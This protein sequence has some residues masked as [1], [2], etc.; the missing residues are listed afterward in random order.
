MNV[1][2]FVPRV[3]QQDCLLQ[4]GRA[5]ERQRDYLVVATPGGG[6]TKLALSFAQSLLS[7]GAITHIH[8]VT[9]STTLR[10]QWNKEA[11]LFG[12]QL[13]RR[14]NGSLRNY[15]LPIDVGG[16]AATYH[17]VASDADAHAMNIESAP[18][19]SLVIF[20]ECHHLGDLLA[21]G[22]AAK[23]A[24]ESARF[25]LHLSG[26]PFRNDGNVIP[27]VHFSRDGIA[28]A[29]GDH[30]YT[31]SYAQAMED[32]V[33]RPIAFDW[34]NLE[35]T[36]IAHGRE[37][38]VDFN[39]DLD[40]KHES[41][42]LRAA[43]D[44]KSPLVAD[45]VMMADREISGIR[46]RGGRFTDA[47]GLLVAMNQKHALECAKVIEEVTGEV[48]TVVISDNDTADDELEAFSTGVGRWIVAVR[49]IS[50]GVD[51]PRLMVG[52]YASN[53]V[54]TLFFRQFV[55]RFVR[56]RHRGAREMAKMFMPGDERFKTLA[57]EILDE[58][59]Q[60]MRDKELTRP[61]VARAL[62]DSYDTAGI[63]V[64]RS[65]LSDGGIIIGG[66]RFTPEEIAEAGRFRAT[67]IEPGQYT[68][69][70]IALNLARMRDDHGFDVGYTG[71]RQF[72]IAA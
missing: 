16:V 49:K 59:R 42:R 25:R 48:A 22:E 1:S 39:T 66:Y 37:W 29:G 55:G 19:K 32:D 9:P 6:K 46:S 31:Y 57:A 50:E 68:N 14:K 38:T 70:Q 4:L 30:G 15:S 53:V 34:K 61:E 23:L 3:W 65:V 54:S 7:S 5:F 40:G 35:N 13:V 11:R 2:N 28:V 44:V 12:I 21:W 43:L 33:C 67:Q 20:D 72:E 24:F 51:I 41:A 10:L 71:G 58:V 62:R 63:V 18:D 17:Q 27:W 64:R 56:V 69:E 60:F 36:Y 26:T 8:V 45:L 47:G 52:V